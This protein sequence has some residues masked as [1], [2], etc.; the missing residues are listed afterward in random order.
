M[1]KPILFSVARFLLSQINDPKQESA[2][3][4]WFWVAVGA[5]DDAG[6][7][8]IF[9]EVAITRGLG[10]AWT[11][12]R[13]EMASVRSLNNFPEDIKQTAWYFIMAFWENSSL[14]K[15][16][17][18]A[19]LGIVSPFEYNGK[20]ILKERGQ[21]E[22]QNFLAK[23]PSQFL[24]TTCQK[25]NYEWR[26][27]IDPDKF[28][29]PSDRPEPYDQLN[30]AEVMTY[31]AAYF[32]CSKLV[33][34]P[35]EALGINKTIL[36]ALG[37]YKYMFQI[38]Y[39]PSETLIARHE[40]PDE[41]NT[42][43]D[44]VNTKTIIG[45][46]AEAGAAMEQQGAWI[47]GG[48]N[49]LENCVVKQTE[50][51]QD[52]CCNRRAFPQRC[53]DYLKMFRD[54]RTMQEAAVFLNQ[55]QPLKSIIDKQWPKQ[56]LDYTCQWLCEED[57][58]SVLSCQQECPKTC[59]DILG[60][61]LAEIMEVEAFKNWFEQVLVQKYLK[62]T[63]LEIL[64]EELRKLFRSWPPKKI[65]KLLN[66]TIMGWFV[67]HKKMS[68]LGK[69]MVDSLGRW[70]GADIWL[71]KALGWT[72]GNIN[73]HIDNAVVGAQDVIQQGF[74]KLFV[75]TPKDFMSFVAQ[76]LHSDI[77]QRF[78]TRLFE[79]ATGGC[80]VMAEE[81]SE[82]FQI[83]G[84]L[85][86]GLV[87]Q[88]LD[89]ITITDSLKGKF[90]SKGESLSSSAVVEILDKK[91]GLEAWR[92]K[93]SGRVYDVK[94]ETV[95]GDKLVVYKFNCPPPKFFTK[96]K[97]GQCCDL[98]K[99][100]V[101][102]DKQNNTCKKCRFLQA[103]YTTNPCYEY[104]SHEYDDFLDNKF[105]N[106][107]CCKTLEENAAK[108]ECCQTVIDCFVEKIN[109]FLEKEFLNTLKNKGP[110]LPSIAEFGIIGY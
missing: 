51:E 95:G 38:L 88:N 107:R 32:V 81:K 92:I 49:V 86:I 44:F 30:E 55:N 74:N 28:P 39:D 54:G 68:F 69:P 45:A 70:V 60:K 79:D 96:E 4:G 2:F 20:S 101:C 6:L 12:V 23:T 9:D 57:C 102:E 8:V 42:L 76:G 62:R 77:A 1:E 33:V 83:T 10:D 56:L 3:L 7:R 89:K 106:S 85:E 15:I 11:L 53:H 94:H 37:N 40:K 66:E 27:S 59:S 36:D 109:M 63:P 91:D 105:I 93:N 21:G 35:A 108:G 90:A 34:K 58:G 46:L 99:G 97:G 61:S 29:R 64:K 31:E 80:Q 82:F 13:A 67:K 84:I 104:E 48:E 75:E 47:A 73:A 98:G 72:D 24:E 50:Q 78:T 103:D 5:T 14:R 87:M 26:N 17:L 71:D 110:A 65:R 19:P 100:M 52:A 18:D 25:I 22:S 41:L 16:L 43:L